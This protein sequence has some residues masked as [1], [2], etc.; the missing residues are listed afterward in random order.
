MSETTKSKALDRWAD[1]LLRGRQRGLSVAQTRRMSRQLD[2]VRDRVLRGARLRTGQ[3]VL[4]V[5]AGTGLLALTA[6]RRVGPS[7]KVVALDISKDALRECQRQDAEVAPASPLYLI[8]G[9]AL[10]LPFCDAVFDAV[11][12][13]SVLIYLED[14]AAVIRELH[15][16]LRPGGR[17][18]IW[19]PIND[20]PNRYALPGQYTLDSGLDLSSIQPAHDQIKAYIEE[21][22][23]HKQTMMAFDERDLVRW[24]AEAGFSQVQL[25]YELRYT[26]G[27]RPTR[28]E[29]AMYLSIR[30][31]PTMLSYEEAAR[32]VLGAAA[33]EHLTRYAR[34]LLSHRRTGLAA[35]AVITARR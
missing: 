32:A 6:C 14:K 35:V 23:E 18:S 30:P 5:G 29:V 19:E 3:R 28:Q 21:R 11:M 2:R 33:D 25:D 7:G 17:A 10:H 13:R 27:R 9:D 1:W 4:D 24:F 31:N 20:A 8:V 26:S 34:L 16:V 22:W 15:R 12:T